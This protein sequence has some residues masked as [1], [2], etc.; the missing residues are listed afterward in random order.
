MFIRYAKM[1]WVLYMS[2]FSILCYDIALT[3]SA[4]VKFKMYHQIITFFW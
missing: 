2:F 3:L 4:S 1:L